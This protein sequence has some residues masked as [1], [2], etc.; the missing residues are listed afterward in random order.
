[1]SQS[2]QGMPPQAAWD[3]YRPLR[4]SFEIGYWL[5]SFCLAAFVNSI[6]VLMDYQRDGRQIEAWKPM[7]WEWS[8]ALMSLALVPAMLWFTRRYPLHFD[9]WRRQL[10]LYLLASVAW[11]L[12]HVV[13]MVVLRKIAYAAQ[14]GASS[15]TNTSKT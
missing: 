4:R 14:G 12:L 5:V 8:S 11:S 10:P 6:T 2:P 15:P 3:R 1:M 7:V 13:G 9:T